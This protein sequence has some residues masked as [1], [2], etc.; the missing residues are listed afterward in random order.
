MKGGSCWTAIGVWLIPTK[1]EVMRTYRRHAAAAIAVLVVAMIAMVAPSRAGATA[2]SG[3]RGSETASYII[4]LK[5]GENPR[6]VAAVAKVSPSFVYEHALTGFAATLNAG[7]LNALR[8]HKAVEAIEPD[9]AIAADGWYTQTTG[10]DGQPW[11]LDRIDQRS[12]LSR[13]FT[14]WASGA[15]GMGTGVNAY[16]I[17]SGIATANP[18]FGGRATNV[19]DA[20]GGNGQDCNGHGTHV[21][22]TLGGNRYG[23]AKNVRLK[24]VRVMDCNGY[25]P[26]NSLSRAIAGV[27]WVAGYAVKPAVAN[28]SWHT[29]TGKSLALNTAT[30]NLVN[31]G[32][33][34]AV[35]A[36]NDAL[37]S[38]ND[39]PSS[40][41]GTV[42]VAASDSTDSRAWF[43]N[44]GAC[45]D[46]YAPG[47][48]ITSAYLNGGVKT[49]A[50]TSM[51][52]PHVAGVAALLKSDYGDRASSTIASWIL[53]ASTASVIKGN[54]IGTPNRL[55]YMSGW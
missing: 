53:N 12:G 10:S 30:T 50:G 34:V 38:C 41:A 1:E 43:S 44:Y 33:F 8:H 7:Q 13:T 28:M 22:G 16:V 40:A 39:S 23:V 54:I 27:D 17:D 15:Y 37:D 20:F 6:S 14:Y 2:A 4:T 5:S 25:F 26:N 35:A 21:A 32:V 9:Q 51:A 42:T 29:T 52:S 49:M 45:V 3:D 36:A 48:N 18:D 19:Y 46:I 47:V 55:L 24:G 11:G 31:R